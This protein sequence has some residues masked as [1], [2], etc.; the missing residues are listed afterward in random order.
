MA[1]SG[2]RGPGPAAPVGPCC[3]RSACLQQPMRPCRCLPSLGSPAVARLCAHSVSPPPCSQ[4]VLPQVNLRHKTH[5]YPCLLSAQIM[6]TSPTWKTPPACPLWRSCSGGC[7]RPQ[8]AVATCRR[9]SRRR[10]ALQARTQGHAWASTR[11]ARGARPWGASLLQGCVC[12]QTL[13][14]VHAAYAAVCRVPPCLQAASRRMRASP[15]TRR[16]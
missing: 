7:A 14:G 6:C 5:N 16:A 4:S 12:R 13:R 2:G 11:A 15:R 1:G 9:C 10:L 3:A 8:A